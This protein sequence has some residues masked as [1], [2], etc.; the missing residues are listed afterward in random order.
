MIGTSSAEISK[1]SRTIAA[2]MLSMWCS[3]TT[4]TSRQHSA[5]LGWFSSC[6]R[7]AILGSLQ[8]TGGQRYPHQHAAALGRQD[9]VFCTM[10]RPRDLR[11]KPLLTLG[12]VGRWSFVVMYFGCGWSPSG[13]GMKVSIG[14]GQGCL[15]VCFDGGL[16]TG[17]LWSRGRQFGGRQPNPLL[18]GVLR[19]AQHPRWRAWGVESLCR[20]LRG[21]NPQ[22]V[23]PRGHRL[24]LCRCCCQYVH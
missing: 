13:L 20:I 15:K 23:P 9:E 2:R 6:E 19:A 22:V 10:R 8:R 14:I 1:V 21:A 16:S 7:M 4:T 3:G 18:Q 11:W 12:G 24:G 5:I 17:W